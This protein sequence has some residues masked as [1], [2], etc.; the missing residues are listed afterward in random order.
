MA[1]GIECVNSSNPTK[2][3]GK[4]EENTLKNFRGSKNIGSFKW[5]EGSK[6]SSRNSTEWEAFG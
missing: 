6:N 1:V 4:T 5:G 3:F 2:T